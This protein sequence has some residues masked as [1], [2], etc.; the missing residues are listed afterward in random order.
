MTLLGILWRGRRVAIESRT[1]A[2]TSLAHYTS[3]AGLQGILSRGKLWA[4]NVAF[5][6]DREELLHGVK[7]AKNSLKTILKDEVLSHWKNDISDVV[8]EIENGRLPN[9]YATCFCEKSDLLS[10]WR[11][12]GGSEQGVALVF[13]RSGI[14]ALAAGKKSFL[15]PVQYGLI[16]GKTHLRKSLKERLLTIQEEDFV[17]MN[18]DEKKTTVYNALSDLIPR[19]KHHGFRGEMEWRLVAQHETVRDTVKFRP[20]KNVLVPYIEFG[21]GSL[22]LKAVKVGPGPDQELTVKSI[23]IF[24]EAQGYEVPI[25]KSTVPFR[26]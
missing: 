14:E 23:A 9:T 20:S 6:N 1:K 19:F 18:G 7:C 16:D 10:Q 12:Y 15:A 24:L 3:L 21:Q 26:N 4:S 2:V 13:R 11:G 8:A 5:L 25:Y 22:P 17:A